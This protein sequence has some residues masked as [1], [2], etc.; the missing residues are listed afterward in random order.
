MV[1]RQ[2]PRKQACGIGITFPH[3]HGQAAEEAD[4]LGEDLALSPVVADL[5]L[6]IV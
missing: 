2:G 6:E 4:H 1:T 3:R 5:G